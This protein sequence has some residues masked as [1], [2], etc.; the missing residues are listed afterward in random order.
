M[1]KKLTSQIEPG[2]AAAP[3]P[4]VSVEADVKPVAI[5]R[6]QFLLAAVGILLTML[7]VTMIVPVLK[8]L[9]SERFHLA[10]FWAHAFMSTSLAGS[11]LL[12]PFAGILIDRSR[13]RRGI[14]FFALSGEALCFAAMALAPSFLILMLARFIEGGMH[15]AALSA[16]LAAGADLSAGPPTAGPG[17]TRAGRVMGALGGVL[18]LGISIGVPLGGV[19]A[20]TDSLRVLWAAALVAGVTALLA[21]AL[22]PGRKQPNPSFG[23]REFAAVLKQNHWLALPYAYSFIDRLCIGVV[24]STLTLYM[25]DILRFDPAQRGME[26][27]FFL[28]PFAGLSY[29]V[30]RLSDRIGRVWLMASGSLLF[31]FVF[32]SYGYLSGSGMT[33]AMIASG[34]LSAVMFAPNLAMCKDLSAPEN[35]GTAFA[36]YNVAGSLGFMAGP[37]LG[38]GL[39]AGF[40]SLFESPEAYRYTFLVAGSF[41]VLCALISLPFLARLRRSKRVL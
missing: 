10:P 40:N 41:E 13:S 7:P 3:A 21:L 16:W 32:M 39:F 31:G 1:E 34:V 8:E 26:L 19:I 5:P 33:V 30:G 24:V 6:L 22:A 2:A 37:L 38:G 35:H 28:L 11:I 23:L 18:M 20:K 36:G 4:A 15:I 25:T 17:R 27:A 29:F 14:I 12:A 9:V